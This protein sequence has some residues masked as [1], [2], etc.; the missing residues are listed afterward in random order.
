MHPDVDPYGLK[1]WTLSISDTMVMTSGLYLE[2]FVCTRKASI[3]VMA[4]WGKARLVVT[5]LAV[6]VCLNK[7]RFTSVVPAS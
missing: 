4:D 3:N 6:G 7:S 2:L 5:K 1:Q